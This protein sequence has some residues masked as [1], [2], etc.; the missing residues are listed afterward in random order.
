MPEMSKAKE[1]RVRP[2]DLKALDESGQFKGLA[3]VYTVP[4][5]FNDVIEPGAFT[6]TIQHKGGKFPMLWNHIMSEP[7]GVNSVEDSDQGL[8]VT[9]KIN[10]DVV[11]GRETHALMKQ[12]KAEGLPFGLSIGFDTIQ[13]EWAGSTRHVKEIRLWEI[14]PTLF[15]A[16]R[17]ATVHDVKAHDEKSEGKPVGPYATFDEC[18]SDNQDKDNPEGYCAFLEQQVKG[19][20]PGDQSRWQARIDAMFARNTK[21]IRVSREEVAKFCASCAEKMAASGLA[22]IIITPSMAKQLPEQL[23]RGIAD[24]YSEQKAFFADCVDHPPA[25]VDDPESFCAWL[26]YQCSGGYPA[27]V[28]T[29]L[30]GVRY[31]LQTI[32]V[33]S[34]RALSATSYGLDGKSQQ[35]VSDVHGYLQEGLMAL[36]VLLLSEPGLP[37]KGEHDRR[38]VSAPEVYQLSQLMREMQ[39]SM[40]LRHAG[41]V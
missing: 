41:T 1:R 17:L 10:L 27:E 7:I 5:D 3:A 26:Q 30:Q 24:G 15:P 36:M 23:L 32:A 35:L 19:Q 8:A 11:R 12:A 25:G 34:V 22:T 4:D 28:A 18:V 20:W 33:P 21:G 2:F 14:S 9:G 39:S 31:V 40:R 29:V 6:R 38:S 16:Q 13:A 37:S